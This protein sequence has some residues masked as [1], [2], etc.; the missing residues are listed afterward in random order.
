MHTFLLPESVQLFNAVATSSKTLQKINKIMYQIPFYVCFSN[1]STD[2]YTACGDRH[3]FTRIRAGIFEGEKLRIEILTV[4]L[5]YRIHI[6]LD[7]PNLE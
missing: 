6:L 3:S 4:L 2:F 5:D 1:E 7:T